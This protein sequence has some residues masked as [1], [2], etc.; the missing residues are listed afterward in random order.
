MYRPLI[1]NLGYKVLLIGR[2]LQLTRGMFEPFFSRSYVF[3]DSETSL[4]SCSAPVALG[5]ATFR[6][7]DGQG[8]SRDR[9]LTGPSRNNTQQQHLT[10]LH[11]HARVKAKRPFTK[12]YLGFLLV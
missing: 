8:P 5:Q 6:G 2:Q 9:C 10:D 11:L 3:G 12:P 7:R 1:P 4:T